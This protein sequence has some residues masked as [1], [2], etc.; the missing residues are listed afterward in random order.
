MV[1]VG[2]CVVFLLDGVRG[3]VMEVKENL[4]CVIWEDHFTSWERAELLVPERLLNNHFK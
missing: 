2:D 3:T 4:C 1:K